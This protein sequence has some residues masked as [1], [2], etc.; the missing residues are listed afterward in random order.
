MTFA[1]EEL[2]NG[3]R[4]EFDKW[5]PNDLRRMLVGYIDNSPVWIIDELGEALTAELELDYGLLVPSGSEVDGVGLLFEKSL[6]NGDLFRAA[7]GRLNSCPNEIESRRCPSDA[8]K[9]RWFGEVSLHGE[10]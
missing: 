1:L 2:S 8:Q 10:I 3:K 6:S 7:A 4:L 5:K 9:I